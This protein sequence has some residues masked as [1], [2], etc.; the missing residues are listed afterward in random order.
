MKTR[1]D[2]LHAHFGVDGV[3]AL[4][5]SDRLAVPLVTTFHGFDVLTR[6]GWWMAHPSIPLVVYRSFI[7]Q[8]KERG[9][10]FIA[11]S[12][13]VERALLATG[14]PRDR[15][16]QHY[17]GVDTEKF[18]PSESLANAGR[19]VLCVGRH[20]EFKGIDVLLRAF[21]RI[22]GKHLDVRLI[23]V[24][25]GPLSRICLLYTSPSPRD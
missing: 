15:V 16:V 19:Y 17:I 24:G 21:A 18:A 14:F 25:S 22:A 3:Y 6:P 5:L 1:P 20:V 10:R 13:F 11:V 2:L 8:L 23:Q 12:K 7:D 9:S 4:P